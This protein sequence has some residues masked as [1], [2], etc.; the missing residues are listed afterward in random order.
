MMTMTNNI[1]WNDQIRRAIRDSGLSLY[2]VA[3]DAGVNVAPIQR[4]MAGEHGMTIDSAEKVCG[5]VGL[6]LRATRKGK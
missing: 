5:V 4:F 2:A 6:E 3:R 1:G